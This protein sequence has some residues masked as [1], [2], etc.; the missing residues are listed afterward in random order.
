MPSAGHANLADV[1]VA[2]V[3]RGTTGAGERIGSNQN[4][5]L[6]FRTGKMHG[7]LLAIRKNHS[8]VDGTGGITV[9]GTVYGNI[10]VERETRWHG[11]VHGAGNSAPCLHQISI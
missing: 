8:Q 1:N 9:R 11:D 4:T 6:D 3:S 10:R 2:L 7:E 5:G